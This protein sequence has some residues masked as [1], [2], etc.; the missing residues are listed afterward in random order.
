MDVDGLAL[1]NSYQRYASSLPQEVVMLVDIG[2][3]VLNIVVTSGDYP[4]VMRDASV[5]GGLYEEA[6]DDRW[7]IRGCG[8]NLVPTDE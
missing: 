6:I 7:L 8:Q 1:F 4:I 2:A 3:S 5:G